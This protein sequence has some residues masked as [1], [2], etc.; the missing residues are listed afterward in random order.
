[1]EQG[2]WGE[3]DIQV[4]LTGTERLLFSETPEMIAET[5]ERVIRQIKT[6]TGDAG[7]QP[8]KYRNV[9]IPELGLNAM[10]T[11]GRRTGMPGV[12]VA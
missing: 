1:M 2:P 5:S 11:I 10:W 9:P 12:R 4:A 3:C 7:V 6:V 8:V